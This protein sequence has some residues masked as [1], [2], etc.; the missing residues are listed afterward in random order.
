MNPGP[1]AGIAKGSVFAWSY[2]P[3]PYFTWLLLRMPK[4]TSDIEVS[5]APGR[6]FSVRGK[7]VDEGRGNERWV[8]SWR[9][10][11]MKFD[12]YIWLLGKIEGGR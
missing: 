9:G 5:T 6:N 2:P 1:I 8:R 7:T 3:P 4:D 12:T 11:V 10:R